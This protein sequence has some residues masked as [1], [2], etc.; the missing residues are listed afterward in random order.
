MT[1]Y[2]EAYI[3]STFSVTNREVQCAASLKTISD[4]LVQYTL[5]V[6]V[7]NTVE[8]SFKLMK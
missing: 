2:E 5:E 8:V 6:I 7:F 3:L 4:Y 1:Q